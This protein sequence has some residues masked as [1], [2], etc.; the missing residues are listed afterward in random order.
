MSANGYDVTRFNEVFLS[1]SN[2]PEFCDLEK[3][4]ESLLLHVE[5]GLPLPSDM[6]FTL[7]PATLMRKISESSEGGN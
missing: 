7:L 5:V 1:F 4:L 3:W 6:Q 2:R